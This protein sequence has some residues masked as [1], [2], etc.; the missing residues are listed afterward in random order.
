VKDE[1]RRKLL[2]GLAVT[3]P[4]AWTRPVVESV[5]LP[6]HA[7]ATACGDATFIRVESPASS[8]SNA[9]RLITIVNESNIVVAYCCCGNEND[10]IIQ[11]NSLP[12]GTY[13]VFGDTPEPFT[14]TV[15]I[16]T[17]CGTTTV[18]VTVGTG[19]GI[20]LMAT[21]TIPGGSVTPESGQSTSFGGSP[22]LN[23]LSGGTV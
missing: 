20:N 19:D 18:A 5:V 10:L 3:L 11:A 9:A 17:E 7:Q 15:L 16:T 22:P 14:H 4:A 6:A 12:A 1:T 13:R 2:K 8:N 23:C 21:V